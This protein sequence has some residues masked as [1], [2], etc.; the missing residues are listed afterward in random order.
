MIPAGIT[1]LRTYNKDNV[2]PA[3]MSDVTGKVASAASSHTLCAA[4]EPVYVQ[5]SYILNAAGEPV[6]LRPSHIL[7]SDCIYI[8][9]SDATGETVC[10]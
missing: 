10:V 3:D 2:S 8:Q 4:G 6:C 9:E 7:E 1:G 5:P